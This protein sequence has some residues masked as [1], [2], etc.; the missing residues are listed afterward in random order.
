[1]PPRAFVSG[2]W[3]STVPAVGGEN[4]AIR[5]RAVLLPQPEG[6]SR[7][8]HSPGRTSRSSPASAVTPRANRCSTW[9][10]R[11]TGSAIDSASGTGGR[12]T[13]RRLL[14]HANFSV[15]ELQ[16]VGLGQVEVSR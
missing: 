7:L 10:R 2:R 9:H 16:R 12:G 6:P 8:S 3:R 13:G 5:R 4:P 14:L 1:M 15:D 11:T